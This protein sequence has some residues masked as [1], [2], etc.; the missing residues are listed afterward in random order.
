ME[1]KLCPKCGDTKPLTEEFFYKARPRKNHAKESWQ[2]FCKACWKGVNRANKERRRHATAIKSPI[3]QML[4]SRT[5]QNPLPLVQQARQSR[6]LRIVSEE[7]VQ[8]SLEETQALKG[9]IRVNQ[10]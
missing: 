1:E 10:N 4:G 5:E 7:H 9:D 8:F 2:S 6:I 3:R